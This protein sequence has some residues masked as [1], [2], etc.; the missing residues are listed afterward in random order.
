M[1]PS[2]ADATSVP[3]MIIN[4]DNNMVQL[5]IQEGIEGIKADEIPFNTSTCFRR[6][7]LELR[8]QIVK[9]ACNAPRIL[10]VLANSYSLAAIPSSVANLAVLYASSETRAMALEAL[11]PVLYLHIQPEYDFGSPIASLTPKNMYGEVLMTSSDIVYFNSKCRDETFEAAK[12]NVTFHNGRACL[13][14]INI[15]FNTTDLKNAKRGA[16][17][18]L[19]VLAWTFPAAK[20]IFVDRL[21]PPLDIFIAD[22]MSTDDQQESSEYHSQSSDSRPQRVTQDQLGGSL[23][24]IDLEDGT[25]SVLDDEMQNALAKLA[26]RPSD[27]TVLATLGFDVP[28]IKKAD[29][30]IPSFRRM[31]LTREGVRI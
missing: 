17:K 12:A 6:L 21:A 8:H 1:I 14:V 13:N 3:S 7:P 19:K 15:A 9:E 28:I 24:M 5:S 31:G 23:E 27:L 20:F 11:K 22:T 4:S 29:F 2:G 10:M 26:N 30:K 25:Y 16:Y 18:W